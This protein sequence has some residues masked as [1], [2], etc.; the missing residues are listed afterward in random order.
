VSAVEPRH[1]E[2]TVI[3]G[4]FRVGRLLARGGMGAVYVAEQLSTGQARALKLLLPQLTSD[5]KSRERFAA[6]ARA[7][8]R[9]ESE[10]VV[11]TIAA[12]VD[13]ATGVPWLAMELLRGEPLAARIA[14]GPLDPREARR[15]LGE[16][17][18][19]LAAAH[20]VGLVHRDLKP[21]NVFLAEPRGGGTPVVK[22]LDFGIAKAVHS[23]T[24]GA[25]SS[26]LGSP[27]WMSPEQANGEPITVATDVWAFGLVA[28]A[29]LTGRTYWKATSLGEGTIQALLTEILIAPLA[30]ASERAA[31]QGVPLP[32][33]FDAWF[34]G[35]VARSPAARFPSIEASARALDD[36]LS[37][38]G[39]GTTTVVRASGADEA[40]SSLVYAPTAPAVQVATTAPRV[41]GTTRAR[42][43]SLAL[44]GGAL[45][46]ATLGALGALFALRG[47]DA[48]VVAPGSAASSSP[49]GAHE[50]S[51]REPEAQVATPL[52]NAGPSAGPSGEPSGEPASEPTTSPSGGPPSSAAPRTSE[53]A[54]APP[55]SAGSSE[56]PAPVG[57]DQGRFAAL[58]RGCIQTNGSSESRQRPT[59]LT[60]EVGF[61]AT[62]GVTMVRVSGE[63]EAP[64]R[65]CIVSL[66][67]SF[68]Y[69]E[70]VGTRTF[71]VS[72]VPTQATAPTSPA[73]PKGQT[74][75]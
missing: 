3:G 40:A 70:K 52:P 30:P 28:Y 67:Q 13:E 47:S 22:I 63:T 69:A 56:R 18:L 53:P 29:A 5:A 59:T 75:K 55:K 8:G 10:H 46:V 34:A 6:E 39:W 12:G 25:T 16:L 26:G 48:R 49:R 37:R 14:R 51:A 62:G 20:R 31:A 19:G 1:L 73:P 60:V 65:T 23:S 68:R 15:V 64:V 36:E 45:A 74:K 72:Y 35:A 61:T 66:A 24:S 17:A 42:G 38:P 9:V 41:T 32:R 57:A 54:S 7:P 27:A 2:G 44:V 58:V 43:P 4:D 50:P 11:E 71:V 21:E 33:S